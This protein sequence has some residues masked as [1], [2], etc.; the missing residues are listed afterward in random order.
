M[1]RACVRCATH[2]RCDIFNLAFHR[3]TNILRPAGDTS[4]AEDICLECMAEGASDT[5]KYHREQYGLY[6]VRSQIWLTQAHTISDTPDG[7]SHCTLLRG[8]VY[9]CSTSRGTQ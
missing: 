9:V 6:Q 4:N 2:C 7:F 8:C 5:K 1:V 3:R